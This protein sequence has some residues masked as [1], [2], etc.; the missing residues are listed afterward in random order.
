MTEKISTR[1]EA[2]EDVFNGVMAG[3]VTEQRAE[4]AER[5]LRGQTYLGALSYQRATTLRGLCC[6][7]SCLRNVS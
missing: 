6:Y 5:M 1:D 2:R 7:G 4:V 3:T